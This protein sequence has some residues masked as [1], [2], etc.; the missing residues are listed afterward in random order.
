MNRVTRSPNPLEQRRNPLRRADL[1]DQVD[2][3]D[4]DA[5]LERSR[6]HQRGELP[7][8]QPVF[9]SQP[10]LFGKA[11]VVCGDSIGA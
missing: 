6:G 1:A 8:L 4:V 9:G 5:K 7:G 2:R 3:T 11:P 10:H